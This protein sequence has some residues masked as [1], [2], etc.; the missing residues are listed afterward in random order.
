[1]TAASDPAPA[2]R[3]RMGTRRLVWVWAFLALPVIFYSVVRFYPTL[4]AFWLSLTNANPGNFKRGPSFVGLANYEK[5]WNSAEF[6]QVFRNT[7]TYLLIG[8]KQE[9]VTTPNTDLSPLH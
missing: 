6:W 7:F 8:T 3:F 1:M 9:K 5:L 4:E 2:P